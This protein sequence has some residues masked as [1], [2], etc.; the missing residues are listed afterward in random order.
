MNEWH[1][2]F[3]SNKKKKHTKILKKYILFYKLI[4][5]PTRF[6]MNGVWTN[7]DKEKKSCLFSLCEEKKIKF[8]D[9][10]WM[11]DQWTFPGKKTVTLAGK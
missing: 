1:V 10:E 5:A 7:S 6:W 8:P 9:F 3:S 4:E 2:N 11:N